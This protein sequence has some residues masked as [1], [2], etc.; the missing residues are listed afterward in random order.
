MSTPKLAL[1]SQLSSYPKY[2][3]SRA[4]YMLQFKEHLLSNLVHQAAKQIS[5][6]IPFFCQNIYKW[7]TGNYGTHKYW[8]MF[9]Y[10]R[11]KEGIKN[12]LNLRSSKHFFNI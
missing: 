10:F 11:E 5:L 4:L 8:E 12:I 2:L 3:I 1:K 9:F 7:N 6:K